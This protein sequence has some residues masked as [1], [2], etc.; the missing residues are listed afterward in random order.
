MCLEFCQSHWIACLVLSNNT[1]GSLV[2]C[3]TKA[4][5]TSRMVLTFTANC[6]IGER[7]LFL[8]PLTFMRLEVQVIAFLFLSPMQTAALWQRASMAV[9][10]HFFQGKKSAFKTYFWKP[11]RRKEIEEKPFLT[12]LSFCVLINY[13]QMRWGQFPVPSF[14]QLRFICT[15]IIS[16]KM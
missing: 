5:I 16:G 10:S 9:L 7:F 1:L 14:N 15:I 8:L 3:T 11:N 12:A 2:P 13:W 6:E 4:V